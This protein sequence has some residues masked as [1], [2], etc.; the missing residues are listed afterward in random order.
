M[1]SR[2]YYS[3]MPFDTL[4]QD[5]ELYVKGTLAGVEEM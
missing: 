2:T 4:A 1:D 5:P 3:F